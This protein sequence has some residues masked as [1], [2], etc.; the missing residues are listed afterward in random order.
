MSTLAWVAGTQ[1][2]NY[3]NTERF[4]SDGRHKIG[5]SIGELNGTNQNRRWYEA[6]HG[7]F[8]EYVIQT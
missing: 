5:L 8:S 4:A 2:F 7:S 3:L 6:I 1:K